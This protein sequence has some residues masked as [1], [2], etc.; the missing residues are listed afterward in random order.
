M[1]MTIRSV[2]ARQGENG[3][4][5]PREIASAS[6]T[7]EIVSVPKRRCLAIDGHGSPGDEAFQQAIA[8]LYGTAY[9]LKFSRKKA[10]KHDFKIGPLEGH[11][12]ADV[13]AGTTERPPES[14]WRWRLRIGVP[15]DVTHD[16]LE[17]NKREVVTKK[18]GKLAGSS[19]VPHVFVESIPAERVGRV[20]HVGPYAD[21][22]ASFARIA[23]VLE[24]AGLKPAPTHIEVYLNDPRRARPAALRT[25][26]LRQL[27]A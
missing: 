10:G 5:T 20:L 8:A 19:T 21:E 12:A 17:H 14:T 9:A 18:H 27:A 2:K 23:A 13:P 16:E 22:P 4:P 3:A 1:C 26:L 6:E 15:S 7:P 25:V 11:W 24:R